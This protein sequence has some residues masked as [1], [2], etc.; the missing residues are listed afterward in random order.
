MSI[1]VGRICAKNRFAFAYNNISNCCQLD[2]LTIT[3][4][5]STLPHRVRVK[6]IT[7]EALTDTTFY[8]HGGGWGYG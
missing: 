3:S 7:N 4:P 8:Y 6:A 5:P 1:K 2:L